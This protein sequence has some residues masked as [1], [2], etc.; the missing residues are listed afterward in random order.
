MMIEKVVSP[1]SEEAQPRGAA[2]TRTRLNGTTGTSRRSGPLGVRLAAALAE[3]AVHL[4]TDPAIG[5]IKKCE[6]GDRNQ[7]ASGPILAF[8]TTGIQDQEK[9][10]HAAGV[11]ITMPLRE[12]PWGERLFQIT[13]PNGVIIQFLEWTAP[14]VNSATEPSTN[15]EHLASLDERHRGT[16]RLHRAGLL[17]HG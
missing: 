14:A 6:A 7:R 15:P 4:L 11:D 10:L 12:E 1:V 13:D 3:A 8:T 5:R 16:P 17:P 2:C 9:R